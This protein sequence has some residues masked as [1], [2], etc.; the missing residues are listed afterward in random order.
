MAFDA[1]GIKIKIND[2]NKGKV[3]LRKAFEEA[4]VILARN[5]KDEKI[6]RK[7][8]DDAVNNNES[9]IGFSMFGTYTQEQD[10]YKYYIEFYVDA[11]I[12]YDFTIKTVEVFD[13]LKDISTAF[14]HISNKIVN[15][16]KENGLC[17]NANVDVLARTATVGT[18]V[19]DPNYLAK[20]KDKYDIAMYAYNA[21]RKCL[22]DLGSSCSVLTEYFS[23]YVNSE[24]FEDILQ[25]VFEDSR[26]K[27]ISLFLRVEETGAKYTLEDGGE[28]VKNIVGVKLVDQ[29][30]KNYFDTFN[31]QLFLQCAAIQC[32]Y[33][34]DTNK[35]RAIKDALDDCLQALI[36]KATNLDL[37]VSGAKKLD[38]DFNNKRNNACITLKLKR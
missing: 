35:S 12:K 1:N 22:A 33:N 3:H 26:S 5:I 38:L 4:N 8:I 20:T 9:K 34:N 13:G 32:P 25:K 19:L 6:L 11:Q 18:I 27:E 16:F 29:D 36:K 37:K 31:K 23:D 7:L 14:K 17:K 24:D 2:L 15:I 21:Q 10:Y 28:L 30:N